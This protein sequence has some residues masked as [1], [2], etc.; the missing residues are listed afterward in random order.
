MRYKVILTEDADFDLEEIYDYIALHDAPAK[1]DYVLDSME[2]VIKS[3]STFP[4][5]GSYPRELLDL[6]IREYR[7]TFFKPYRVIYRIIGSIVYIQLISD[8]R[9]E[10]VSLLARRLLGLR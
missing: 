9:R 1:A 4:E 2:D 5:R 8:G 6:G 3:L 7:Q 10:M